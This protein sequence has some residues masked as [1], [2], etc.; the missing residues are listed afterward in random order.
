VAVAPLAV[1][2]LARPW[3]PLPDTL[4]APVAAL[5]ASAT[6]LA[7]GQFAKAWRRRRMRDLFPDWLAT[8]A[9]ALSLGVPLGTALGL[10][11][12]AT[13][14]PLAMAARRLADRAEAGAED[15]LA[16]FAHAIGTTEASFVASVLERHRHLGVSVASV[17]LEE[18]GLLSRLRWQERRGRQGLVPYAFT[19]GVGVLLVNAAVLFLAPRAAE[20]LTMLDATRP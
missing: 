14:L 6:A 7:G 17:L 1:L 13:D 5:A 3:G 12:S 2:A 8:L 4:A 18:E 11:A 16:E 15:A 9:M 19:A 20:L 10:A